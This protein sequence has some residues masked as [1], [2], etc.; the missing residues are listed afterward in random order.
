MIES[1][2][3]LQLSGAH[4]LRALQHF[5]HSSTQFCS[6]VAVGSCGSVARAPAAKAGDPW[7]G[8]WWLPWVVFFFFF[9]FQLAY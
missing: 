2:R 8:S 3:L 9:L 1:L 6:L 5:C 7:F 4:A